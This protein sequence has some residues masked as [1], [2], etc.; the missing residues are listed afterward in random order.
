MQKVETAAERERKLKL[1]KSFKSLSS[2]PS[3]DN[4]DFE[5]NHRLAE[6]RKVRIGVQSRLELFIKSQDLQKPSLTR[7][8]RLKKGLFGFWD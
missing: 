1:F 8:H 3:N 4:L 7:I 2:N 5:V 6:D